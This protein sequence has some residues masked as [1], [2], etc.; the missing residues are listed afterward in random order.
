MFFSRVALLVA[1]SVA[2]LVAAVPYGG[3]HIGDNNIIN[4]CNT[5]S[6]Q[7]CNQVFEAGSE[8]S[9]WLHGLIG[10]ALGA[11]NAQAGLACNPIT[12][13]GVG[14]GAQCTSQP[15]CCTGNHMNG[16]IAVGCNPINI[17]V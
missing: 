13:I 4:S 12:A 11:V 1:A 3:H 15:V 14:N 8:Q 7:C 5:G 17:N 9:N 16:L 6:V 2:S 10:V